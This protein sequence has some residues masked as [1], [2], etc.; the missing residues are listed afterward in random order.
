MRFFFTVALLALSGEL[1][2]QQPTIVHAQLTSESVD[3]GLAAK[4]AS[5][6]KSSAP[7]W[8]GYAVPTLQPFHANWNGGR[9][10]YLERQ[11]SGGY[12]SDDKHAEADHAVILMRLAGGKIDKLRAESPEQT[13]DVGGIRFVWLQDVT[14]EE[15]VTSLKTIALDP[16]NRSQWD[17]A[18]FLISVHK[19][20]A[21][22]SALVAISGSDNELAAREK[23]A[24]WLAGGRGRE[25][26]EAI[27]KLARTDKNNRLRENL[28]F[29]LT[30]SKDPLSVDEL[31]RMAH[32]DPSPRV[33]QQAQFWMAQTANTRDATKITA[34]LRK[35]AEDDP[36]AQTRR[37]AVFAVSQLTNGE[38]V[39]QLTQLAGNSRHREVREQ[40]VFW[41]GQ[42][43]DPR[44]LDYLTRL[45]K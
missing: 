39:S 28:T 24:F 31:I 38:A 4:L 12:S 29:D 3:R 26:F 13:I 10:S 43:K 11:D 34:G 7:L 23:A 2:A 8:I 6:E 18:I 22:L 9:V 30:L 1:A 44:A 16:A 25:G 14:P 42:S 45:L 40:A 5:L 19:A 15:S 36:D 37:Q 20:S 27:E 33:R 41:L 32:E 17:S 35:S 21:A